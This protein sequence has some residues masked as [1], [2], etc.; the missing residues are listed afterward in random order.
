VSAFTQKKIDGLYELT[1][2]ARAELV[3]SKYFNEDLAPTS[4]SER[5]W[6]TYHISMLW[7]GMSVCIPSFTLATG[8]VGMG[9]SPWLAVLNVILGNLIVLIPIQL[10]SHAGTK[11]GIPF[12]VFA[13]LTFGT[14]GAH[15]PALSR[16]ITACGWNA[17]QSWVGGGAI[18]AMLAAV[19]PSANSGNI[20]YITFFVFLAIT[21]LI[22]AFGA[23]V[24][25]V[26]E[27][28]GS[29]IL[30]VLSI[31]LFIW[32]IMIASGAGASFGDILQASNDEELILSNGG[33]VRGFLAGLTG[34]IAFWATMALNIPDFSRYA[35]SQ[36]VQFRGQ[37]YGM[38]LAMAGCAIIGGFFA[39]ATKV[40]FGTAVFDPTAILSPEYLGTGGGARAIMFI[41]GFG[42]VIATLTTNVAANVVAP[43]NGFSNV[44]PRKISYRIGVTIACLV[45]IVYQ[46][47]NMFTGATG[48]IFNWLNVYGPIVAALTGVII[49][50][51][52]FIKKKNLDVKAL[53]L[54]KGNRYWYQG[55][56]NVKAVVAWAVGLLFPILGSMKTLF[57]D[58]S[59]AIALG[60]SSF[61]NICA[62]NG[63]FVGFGIS[64]I[65]YM[66]I[67]AGD[68]KDALTNEEEAAMTETAGA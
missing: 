28:F 8:L 63:Y 46:P 1:D 45:A 16:A 25:R 18:V 22:T 2:A 55:G 4:V 47:W 67:A 56:W 23:K 50:D 51:Y 65:L 44:A 9:F 3:G 42:V 34:N 19:I 31:A 7:V 24:I 37:F 68:K 33:Y 49:A 27:S 59:F 5:S 39:Q 35:K 26:F 64:F 58:A 52:Y 66:I 17:V 13:R 61:L 20:Q 41:V 11:Y 15:I 40:A 29:P 38:P 21:W 6:N 43:G 10:N 54:G 30:I 57:P 32:S 36:K 53:Y 12:P 48:Y 60:K 62:D 14:V